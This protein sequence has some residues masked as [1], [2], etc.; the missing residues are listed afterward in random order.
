M[1][2]QFDLNGVFNEVEARSL[3]EAAKVGVAKVEGGREG[4]QDVVTPDADVED[5]SEEGEIVQKSKSA[6]FDVH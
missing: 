6:Y 5:G 4:G 2:E 3:V 1:V